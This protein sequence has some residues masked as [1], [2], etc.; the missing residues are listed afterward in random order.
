VE[1]QRKIWFRSSPHS[2]HQ[3]QAAF[4]VG[5]L[6]VVVVVAVTFFISLDSFAVL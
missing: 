6:A 4:T 2:I 3:S 5:L 1:V